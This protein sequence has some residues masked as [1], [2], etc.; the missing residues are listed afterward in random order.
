MNN[1]RLHATNCSPFI[2]HRYLLIPLD[3]ALSLASLIP[4]Q[5]TQ[6]TGRCTDRKVIIA[7]TSERRNTGGHIE[8]VQITSN[9]TRSLSDL[10]RFEII[11]GIECKRPVIGNLQITRHIDVL[12]ILKRITHGVTV[13][14]LTTILTNAERIVKI[15]RPWHLENLISVT[16]CL[17]FLHFLFSNRLVTRR[18]SSLV[19][20]TILFLLLIAIFIF[21]EQL[22]PSIIVKSIEEKLVDDILT[23]PINKEEQEVSN[24]Q[25]AKMEKSPLSEP[26]SKNKNKSD[27][28]AKLEKPSVREEIKQIKEEQKQKADNDL[29]KSEL[30]KEKDSKNKVNE[31]KH[32][33][34][35]NKKKKSKERG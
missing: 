26:T 1:L 18:I 35:K 12:G 34:P 23:K 13:D 33:Q 25:V 20:S 22:L 32:K 29:D 8:T 6:D 19:V 27:Q 30:S 11:S 4:L 5:I 9:R 21:S 3:V 2:V 24:P 31:T 28:G 17:R 7:I 16:V 10:F 15:Q 14:R